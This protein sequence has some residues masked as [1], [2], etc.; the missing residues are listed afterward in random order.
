MFENCAITEAP[1]LPAQ[2]LVKGSY[3]YMFTGC[4]NLNFINC[5]ATSITASSC[6]VSWV[7]NVAS[8]G[9]FIKDASMT[10]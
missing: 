1:E 6:T 4:A 9:T 5:M 3:G 7:N 2:T 10:S 8:S